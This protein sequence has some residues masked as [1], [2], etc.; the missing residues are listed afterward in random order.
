MPNA[1]S[2]G[3]FF[4]LDIPAVENEFL[5]QWTSGQPAAYF[6]N[7]RSALAALIDTEQPG[8]VWLPAFLCAALADA[9]PTPL[10]RYYPVGASLSPDVEA[11]TA[12]RPG[13]LVIA[14]NYFG[15][16][17]LDA[18]VEFA[19]KRTDV[20]FLEDCAHCIMPA[21]AS[22]GHWR[23]FSPRKVVGVADGGILV[24]MRP[25]KGVP[26]PDETAKRPNDLWLA[27]ILRF[28]DE[29]HIQGP[30]WHAANQA[31][32]AAMGV[33]RL[34]MTRLSRQLLALMSPLDM[35]NRRIANFSTLEEHI[36][37]WLLP[38]HRRESDVPFAFP[39]RLSSDIRNVVLKRLHAEEIYAAVHWSEMPSPPESFA[40]EHQLSKELISIPCD[41]RYGNDDMLRIVD[42]FLGAVG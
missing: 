17:P 28:E 3:G 40:I 18:F 34:A 7:A 9:V 31:K 1:K 19:R 35:A 22:W 6:T 14:I 12:A 25:D 42:I 13:D 21:T 8:T 24:S 41:H 27:P 2:I 11:L 37:R 32:E 36:G 23:L 38:L 29:T 39:V 26:L 10:R 15:R 5:A 33:S 20:L 16:A 4:E 30:I